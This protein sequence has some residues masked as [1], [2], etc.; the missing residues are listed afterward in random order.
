MAID[1]QQV[2]ML[3]HIIISSGSVI[4]ACR[5]L[6]VEEKSQHIFKLRILKN[7]LH[8]LNSGFLFVFFVFV[9]EKALIIFDIL[10]NLFLS[11][12]LNLVMA[13]H[14]WHYQRE[15]LFIQ[16]YCILMNRFSDLGIY[17]ISQSVVVATYR[18]FCIW[19]CILIANKLWQFE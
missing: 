17:E 19:S 16:I 12:I 18:I 8:H 1:T 3:K 4:Y 10:L 9:V 6:C 5:V 15:Y 13:A 2:L 14:C 7:V 11:I